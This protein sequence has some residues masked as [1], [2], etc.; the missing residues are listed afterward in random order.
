MQQENFC[1]VITRDDL[2]PKTVK[3][4]GVFG[5]MNVKL[6]IEDE[7]IISIN[8]WRN[9]VNGEITVHLMQRAQGVTTLTFV[10]NKPV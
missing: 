8:C 7:T 1:A 6:L 4:E 2:D 9:T 3:S 10:R 5:G